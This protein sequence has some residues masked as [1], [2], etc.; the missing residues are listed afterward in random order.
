MV[1]EEAPRRPTA[2]E[3]AHIWISRSIARVF[4]FMDRKGS[5]Q[6]WPLLHQ[7]RAEDGCLWRVHQRA[8]RPCHDLDLAEDVRGQD[9]SEV[10]DLA[11]HCFESCCT[12]Y[13]A[14]TTFILGTRLI[15]CLPGRTHPK[16]HLPNQHGCHRWCPH[17]PPN[18]RHRS[19]GLHAR[20]ES[21]LDIVAPCARFRAGLPAE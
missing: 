7:S 1:P 16:R 13:N 5:Q 6:A 14:F 21:Q 18:S 11:D 8:A 10:Q 17:L 4:G 20:H 12:C 3:D 19:R 2:H 15:R 9:E